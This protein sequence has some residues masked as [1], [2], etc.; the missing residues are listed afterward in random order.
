[1]VQEMLW[2]RLAGVLALGLLP[3]VVFFGESGR[4]VHNGVVVQERS[5]NYA[6]IVLAACGIALAAGIVFRRSLSERMDAAPTPLWGRAAA[7][8]LALFCAW[9]VA[10]SA[11]Y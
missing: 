3:Y 6:G 7:A 1:M 11:G 8:A 2:K 9:Q 5:L 4:V 10:V